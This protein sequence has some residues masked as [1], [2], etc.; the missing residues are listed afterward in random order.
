MIKALL[1]GVALEMKLNL[2]LMEDSG[3]HVDTFIATGG[4]TRHRAWTQLKADVLNRPIK[5]RDVSEAGC[6]GAAMLACSAASS[7][8]VA[9]LVTRPAGEEM[10]FTPDPGRAAIYADT[11]AAYRKLYPAL[12]PFWTPAS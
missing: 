4:G 11:Y 9:H 1:E 6:F 2:E 8:P 3:I 10:T 12:R 7:I 5:V